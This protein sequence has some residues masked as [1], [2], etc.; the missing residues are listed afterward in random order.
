MTSNNNP[1]KRFNFSYAFPATISSLDFTTNGETEFATFD[2][3]FVFTEMT[4]DDV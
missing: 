4:I 2:V 3:D 1:L